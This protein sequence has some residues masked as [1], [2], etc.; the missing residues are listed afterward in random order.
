MGR[1]EGEGPLGALVDVLERTGSGVAVVIGCD[2][3]A[4]GARLIDRIVEA[5][6]PGASAAV[7]DDGR[8]HWLIGA[9]RSDVALDPLRRAWD[10]GERSIHRAASGLDIIHVPVEPATALNANRGVNVGA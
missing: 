4:V 7:A 2:T 8:P 9:W 5:L 6:R 3:P 1:R 10:D